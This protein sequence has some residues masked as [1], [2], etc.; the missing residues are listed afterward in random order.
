MPSP[1]YMPVAPARMVWGES[2]GADF[3]VT[4]GT[5]QTATPLT[6][7]LEANRTYYVVCGAIFANS[8]AAAAA[9]LSWTGPAG[10]AMKW[11][12]TTGSTG[13]RSTIGA[14]DSYT[15]STAQRMALLFGRL[16]TGSAGGALT[17]TLSTSDPAQTSTLYADSWLRV[18]RVA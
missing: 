5:A 13:Y 12:N 18:E 11:N 6:V 1:S 4:G 9:G 15:G 7:Q 17:L 14:V 3:P 8:S 2:G 10:A 16:T